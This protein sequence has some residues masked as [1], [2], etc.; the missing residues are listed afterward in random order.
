MK[1]PE[2]LDDGRRGGR[3]VLPGACMGKARGAG[4]VRR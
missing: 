4:Q 1:S 2:A 3:A